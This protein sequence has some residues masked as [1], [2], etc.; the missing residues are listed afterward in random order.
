LQ[1]WVTSSLVIIKKIFFQFDLAILITFVFFFFCLAGHKIMTFHVWPD[2]IYANSSQHIVNHLI[3][4]RLIWDEIGDSKR[5]KKIRIHQPSQENHSNS[6][7]K[8]ISPSIYPS[9]I[10]AIHSSHIFSNNQF[11]ASYTLFYLYFQYFHGKMATNV[12]KRAKHPL[13]SYDDGDVELCD[14]CMRRKF[15]FLV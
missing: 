4:L 13:D 11:L 8:L 10:H 9:P 3:F 15:C 12:G 2:I 14:A 5:K 7:T 1:L 6:I